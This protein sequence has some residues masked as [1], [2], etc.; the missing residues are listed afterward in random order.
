VNYETLNRCVLIAIALFA[1]LL[2][3]GMVYA[4]FAEFMA[5]ISKR[6]KRKKRAR[7]GVRYSWIAEREKAD[8]GLSPTR[9][10]GDPTVKGK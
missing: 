7:K 1:L 9:R 8:L 4:G 5:R 3:I 10:T 2:Y 6:G